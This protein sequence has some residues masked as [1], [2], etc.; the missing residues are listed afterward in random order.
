[1]NIGFSEQMRMQIIDPVK[2][3]WLEL[4]E[5]WRWINAGILLFTLIALFSSLGIG[6]SADATNRQSVAS[7]TI[8]QDETRIAKT[9]LSNPSSDA[10][11]AD[12]F[13]LSIIQGES[14]LTEVGSSAELITSAIAPGEVK[15]HFLDVGQGDCA[16]LELPNGMTMLIDAGSTG[17]GSRIVS[18]IKAMQYSKIDYVIASHPHE[19][20]IGGMPVIISSF[21][22]GEIWAPRVTHTT[23]SYES[24]LDAID[25][26]GMNIRVAEAGK[27]VLVTDS[28]K[29]VILS[30][31]KN[32]APFD[33]N[34]WSVIL[35]LEFGNTAFAFVGDASAAMISGAFQ[36][37]IDVLKV[38]HH[39]SNT[40]TSI[41]VIRKLSPQ[42]A[43]ISCGADNRY[44]H[45]AE[46]T[47]SALSEAQVLRTDILG[48]III[49]SDGS[50]ITIE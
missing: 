20:H 43:I 40:S 5:F 45:P 21:D 50:T 1:M 8:T 30:P 12:T 14:E 22:I 31:P 9:D 33:L 11:I 4:P 44:G 32:A 26:K 34:D 27:A 46:E 25:T 24:F 13:G 7:S 29:A 10:G 23:K 35:N 6:F 38:G 37:S 3:Q 47:L 28:I 39:G 49:S 17:A 16:F 19:D 2:E 48:T 42:L 36:N 18:Y 41:G 15:I